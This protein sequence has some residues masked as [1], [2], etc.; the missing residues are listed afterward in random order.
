M[1]ALSPQ[2]IRAL[3]MSATQPTTNTLSAKQYEYFAELVYKL[4][5][6]NLGPD[7]L[8]LASARISKRI[9]SLKLPNFD[10]Y[11][12][13]LK[14]PDSEAEIPHLIEVISTHHTYFYR[15]NGHFDF[16][17]NTIVPELREKAKTRPWR[18]WSAACSTGEEPATLAMALVDAG[19]DPR[20]FHINCTDIAQDT[21][22]RASQMVFR[23][24][25]LHHLPNTWQQRYF[26]KGINQWRDYSRIVPS[27]RKTMD[28]RILNLAENF[29]WDAPFD[30]IF[31]RN[32]MIYFDR[33]TQFEVLSRCL[34]Y[35]RPG[36]YLITGQSESLAG[37]ELPLTP[38]GVSVYKYRP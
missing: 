38:N 16:V 6:I 37:I 5:R 14:S 25:I 29:V 4:T 18:F 34:K 22:K 10:A 15:E 13:L 30:T 11:F 12:Q 2:S 24:S 17:K 3:A 7:K 9:R 20:Q 19:V 36:G 1:E 27:L 31:I 32:V 26:Q 33:K 21:V 28:F 35:L 23:R 8:E